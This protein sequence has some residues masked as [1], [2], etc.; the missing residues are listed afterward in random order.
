MTN[1]TRRCVL[2]A[3]KSTDTEDK[4]I[5]SIPA[6]LSALRDFAERGGLRIELEL[7]EACSAR[8]PGRPVF[9]KLLQDI[10]AGRVERILCWKLDRLARNPVDGGSLIHLLGKGMLGEIVT[11]E[12]TYT[13]TGDSKFMLA[14]LFGAATKMTDDL[15]VSVKRGNR[16]IHK[17]GRITGN[18][19]LGYMKVRDRPG[20]RGAGK[21]VPDPDRF[22]LVRRIWRELLV[23]STTVAE[24]WRKAASEWGL[25]TRPTRNRPS[26]PVSQSHIY[27]LLESRFYAGEIPRLGEVFPGEHE[28]MVTPEEFERVQRFIRHPNGPRPSEHKFVYRGLLHCGHC[29]GKVL[30]GERHTNRQGHV[31]VYYRC[32]RRRPGYPMCNAPAPS[33]E[34]VTSRILAS[35]ESI[36]LDERLHQ[37]TLGAIDW[38]AEHEKQGIHAQVSALQRELAEVDSQLE[39]A[40][41]MLVKGVLNE[42]S[43]AA[44]RAEIVPR[45]E[46]LKAQLQDPVT[47]IEAWRSAI[48]E[49]VTFGAVAG[50]AFQGGSPEE[51]RAIL[52]RLYEN[53]VV[54]DRNVAPVLRFPYAVL[55]GD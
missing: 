31:Y 44:L 28:P 42:V 30:T 7:T 10:S 26:R 6:Q 27:Q 34:Q 51:R 41:R 13:G 18:P 5:L 22:P 39:R 29:G 33:E 36:H 43:Y 17:S 54:T 24:V 19:P 53:L 1:G 4:Q 45:A 38:W 46:Q 55:D 2:Y 48:D 9:S 14:V 15:S 20:F 49:A 23:G 35:L 25:T 32:S 40:D 52:A 8:E 50:S 37:W 47:G 3:R 12:G 11:P 21:V 16:E